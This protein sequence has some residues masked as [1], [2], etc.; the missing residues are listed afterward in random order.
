MPIPIQGYE[1]IFTGIIYTDIDNLV[2][3]YGLCAKRYLSSNRVSSRGKLVL[4]KLT[5]SYD[6]LVK[7][8]PYFVL[9]I[10]S[11]TLLYLS[12]FCVWVQPKFIL[13]VIET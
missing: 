11:L 8:K 10:S 7:P 6:L 4:P 9:V 3:W 1:S 2:Y 13:F 5:L 12:S